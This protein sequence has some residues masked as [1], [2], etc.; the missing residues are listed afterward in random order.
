M[1]VVRLAANQRDRNEPPIS[2]RAPRIDVI[3]RNYFANDKKL[4]VGIKEQ[5]LKNL[6]FYLLEF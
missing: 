1:N 5:G 4:I 6:F 3:Q 2:K